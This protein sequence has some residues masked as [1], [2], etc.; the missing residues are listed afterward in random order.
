MSHHLKSL[1]RSI[2]SELN[3]RTFSNIFFADRFFTS[4]SNEN[5]LS[6]TSSRFSVRTGRRLFE[7]LQ[8]PQEPTEGARGGLE[9]IQLNWLNLCCTLKLS[10]WAV[11]VWILLYYFKT[12][13]TSQ[14]AQYPISVSAQHCNA[15]VMSFVGIHMLS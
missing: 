15:Y 13:E 1:R 14:R 9:Q 8:L 4:S 11:F 10:Q 7:H 5:L 3:P 6:S 12:E 2:I